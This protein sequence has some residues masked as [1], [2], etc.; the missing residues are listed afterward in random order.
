V[1]TIEK[2]KVK[3]SGTRRGFESGAVRD[4]ATGKGRYD[5]VSPIPLRRLAQLYENGAVKYNARNWEKGMNLAVFYNSMMNH[6]QKVLEGWTDEDHEAAVLWN[7]FGY[8]HTK[9]M[10]KRGLLPKELDD[11]PK[12]FMREGEECYDI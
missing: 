3:D 6:A 11:M 9:E 2:K 4:A 5:L 1:E 7:M 10:I 12:T 8:I